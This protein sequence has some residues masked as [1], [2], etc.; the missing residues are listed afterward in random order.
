M[1]A[2]SGT[3]KHDRGLTHLN[4]S[5]LYWLDV[6]WRTSVAQSSADDLSELY[7]PVAQSRRTT[8][9]SFGQPPPTIVVLRIQLHM[10]VRCALALVGQGNAKD[11]GHTALDVVM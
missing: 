7:T 10:Y 1:S 11:S 5:E 4:H 9:H 8:A 6:A 2:V 3:R